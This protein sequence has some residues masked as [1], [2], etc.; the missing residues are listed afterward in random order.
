LRGGTAQ[1]DSAHAAGGLRAGKV[2]GDVQFQLAVGF[3][4]VV[5]VRVAA[6][7]RPSPEW[8]RGLGRF[9]LSVA[10]KLIFPII[11]VAA[12]LA[13]AYLMNYSGATGTLGLAFSATGRAFPFFS[14]LMGWL[15]SS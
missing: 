15:G 5:H 1:P 14:P 9:F 8:D 13:M 11:T 10:R 7:G 2:C 4:D 3:G 12:M 6:G